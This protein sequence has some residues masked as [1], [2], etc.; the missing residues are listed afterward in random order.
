MAVECTTRK[1]LQRQLLF[2]SGTMSSSPSP[3]LS[4]EEQLDLALQRAA[5]E[6]VLSASRTYLTACVAVYG[7]DFVLTFADEYRTIWRAERWTPVRIAFLINRYWGLLDVIFTMCLFWLKIDTKTCDRIHILN[8]IAGSILL[9]SCE[10][11]LGARVCVLCN[12]KRRKWIAWFFG[13]FAICGFVVQIWSLIPNRALPL[14][15]G[16]RGCIPDLGDQVR[17]HK[18]IWI[19]WLPPLLYDTAATIFVFAS[20]ISHWRK[21]PRTRLLTIF[22]ADGAIYFAVV[23]IC[24]LMNAIYFSIPNVVNPLLNAPLPLIFTT[25]MASRIVLHLRA[26]GPAANSRDGGSSGGS[27]SQRRQNVIPKVGAQN[28]PAPRGESEVRLQNLGRRMEGELPVNYE[29]KIETAAS[30]EK[31]LKPS[32][33]VDGHDEYSLTD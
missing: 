27:G 8:P 20:L 30:L 14:P 22:A 21:T 11:L 12:Y 6:E 25:I 18:Y 10:F 33:D 9:L 31:G 2:N 15:P 24:N 23:F 13:V 7:W 17:N 29:V 32:G 3:S 5:V 4:V 1:W 19:Y 28:Q 16:L 26:V